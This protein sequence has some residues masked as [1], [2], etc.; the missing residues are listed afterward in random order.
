MGKSANCSTNDRLLS[1]QSWLPLIKAYQW[2]CAQLYEVPSCVPV[3]HLGDEK[4]T[5]K[6]EGIQ[7]EDLKRRFKSATS[8]IGWRHDW[9]K[10][11]LLLRQ[12]PPYYIQVQHRGPLRSRKCS[13]DNDFLTLNQGNAR[14]NSHSL[15]ALL[16]LS[17]EPPALLHAW[18]MST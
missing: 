1:C 5:R 3:F 15:L 10:H 9:P 11:F 7:R 16:S 13:R 18:H 14:P 8:Y 17:L 2:V 6:L 4:E 12:G